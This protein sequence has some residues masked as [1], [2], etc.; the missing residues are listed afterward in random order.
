VLPYTFHCS[1]ENLGILWMDFRNSGPGGNGGYHGDVDYRASC[2]SS[3]APPS[4]AVLPSTGEVRGASLMGSSPSMEGSKSQQLREGGLEEMQA[5]PGPH[6]NAVL[7]GNDRLVERSQEVGGVTAA[8]SRR[9]VS[10][11]GM[12][13]QIVTPPKCMR[14]C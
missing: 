2:C 8:T 9:Y 12:R 11:R 1:P 14:P 10:D 3:S 7:L 4:S 13:S 6:H 5:G